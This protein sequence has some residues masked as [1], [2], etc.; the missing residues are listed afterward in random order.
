LSGLIAAVLVTSTLAQ[1]LRTCPIVYQTTNANGSPDLPGAYGTPC[2]QM[3][4]IPSGS[5][6][7]SATTVDATC[8][9]SIY[10]F[11]YFC[12]YQQT[13]VTFITPSPGT[14]FATVGPGSTVTPQNLKPKCPNSAMSSVVAYTNQPVTC[15][16]TNLRNQGCPS[17]WTCVK[18]SNVVDVYGTPTNSQDD[19]GAEMTPNI[20]CK[21][22]TLQS[23]TNVFI[24]SGL[25]PSIVPGAPTAGIDS[26]GLLTAGTTL[27]S[28]DD[29]FSYM[30]GLLFTQPLTIN[31][32]TPTSASLYYHTLMFDSTTNHDCWF[33]ANTLITSNG[34]GLPFTALAAGTGASVYNAG[35]NT[36]PLWTYSPTWKPPT[37]NILPAHRFVVLVWTTTTKLLFTATNIK[38]A[39]ML[40]LFGAINGDFAPS[41]SS[42]GT[43][44][45]G[46]FT[47]VSALL[48][49]KFSTLL[50]TPK[51]GTYF[52]LTS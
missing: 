52:Y 49:G 7:S 42:Q 48:K 51:F 34:T 41:T 17:G 33:S 12:C 22:T 43:V 6:A 10:W 2:Y 39:T 15:N 8:Q 23:Y 32:L 27:I 18:A 9:F 4:G 46:A 26:V 50:G 36:S 14:T 30:S 45:G 35:T 44:V 31:L 28:L 3:S 5:C 37:N 47:T 20:C 21:A 29:D 11:Q 19:L 13:Q 1:S 25:S 38:S 16:M 40:N 24:E